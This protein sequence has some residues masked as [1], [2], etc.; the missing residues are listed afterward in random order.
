MTDSGLEFDLTRRIGGFILRGRASLPA[1]G[2]VSVSG[3]SGAGKTSLLRAIAGLDSG[4]SGQV[5]FAGETWHDGTCRMPVHRRRI[6][7]AFQDTRLFPHQSVAGNLAYGAARAPAK[8]PGPDRAEILQLLD[9]HA[10]L[11]RSVSG[12]SGGERQRVSLGRALLSRPRLLL[13]DEPLSAV[14]TARRNRLL[15]DLRQILLDHNIP[16]LHVSHSAA[17][18]AQFADHVLPLRDGQCGER[19][20]LA[21]WL[22][23]QDASHPFS[24]LKGQLAAHDK[25]LGLSTVRLGEAGLVLPGLGDVPAGASLRLIVRARDVALALDPVPGLSIR[26]QI[27]VRITAIRP[28]PDTAYCDVDLALGEQ[29]LTAKITRAA[30][31]SLSLE[32]GQT[33]IALIKSAT[34]DPSQ[35]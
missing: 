3:S 17:E 9:L 28:Q 15:P 7:I 25:E 30:A 11:D 22:A 8:T 19:Q 26:N 32:T 5:R 27:P 16:A 21:D 24:L 18:I 34:L 23:T 35:D 31:D 20:T 13:L 14:D 29:A 2:I 6:G 12:L 1:C 10:L 4:L 33:V